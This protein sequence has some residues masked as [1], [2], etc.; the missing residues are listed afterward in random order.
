MGFGFL[1]CEHL[2]GVSFPGAGVHGWEH[3]WNLQAGAPEMPLADSGEFVM[4]LQQKQV[5]AKEFR[6]EW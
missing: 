1:A 6:R 4:E 3:L 2:E 5:K